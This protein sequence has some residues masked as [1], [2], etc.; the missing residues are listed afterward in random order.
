MA[1]S[2]SNSDD[3][4]DSRQVIERLD[5]LQDERDSLESDLTEALEEFEEAAER[6][7]DAA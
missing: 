7:F 2:I 1:D 5:E 6:P 3:I 4:I